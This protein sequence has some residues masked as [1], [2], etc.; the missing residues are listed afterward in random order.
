MLAAKAE[1][2]NIAKDVREQVKKDVED[3]EMK[4]QKMRTNIEEV[5]A[6]RE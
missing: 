2:Q 6:E 4:I 5:K 1:L 3:R